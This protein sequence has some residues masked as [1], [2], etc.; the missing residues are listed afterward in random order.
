MMN[1]EE[2]TMKRKTCGHDLVP[3]KDSI[4]DEIDQMAGFF[5]LCDGACKWGHSEVFKTCR[6]QLLILATQIRRN[7]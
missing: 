6:L 1:T 2:K 7:L 5:K 4:A 3:T